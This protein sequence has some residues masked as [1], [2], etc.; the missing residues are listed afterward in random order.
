[1]SPEWEDRAVAAFVALIMLVTVGIIIAAVATSDDVPPCAP[2]TVVA[3]STDVDHV[4][5]GKV[6]TTNRHYLVWV[7]PDG[8]GEP[9]AYEVS[10][11]DQE[12]LEN[13]ARWECAQ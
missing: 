6:M 13:G 3:H 9:R 1:M 2:G 11:D 5:V 10:R 12:R 8:D 4:M 7:R